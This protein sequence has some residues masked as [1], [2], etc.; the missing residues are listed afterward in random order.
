MVRRPQREGVALYFIQETQCDQETCEI[1]FCGWPSSLLA[2]SGLVTH[3]QLFI[4]ELIGFSLHTRLF[5]NLGPDITLVVGI[6]AKGKKHNPV[7][8]RLMNIS[9]PISKSDD[10]LKKDSGVPK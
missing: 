6:W 10:R 2:Q 3:S 9:S 7:L 8:M 4:S 1:R 5:R